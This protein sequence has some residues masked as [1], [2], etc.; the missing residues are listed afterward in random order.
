[1]TALWEYRDA[2]GDVVF[3]V[4][5]DMLMIDPTRPTAPGGEKRAEEPDDFD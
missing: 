1:M 3:V 2:S 4:T 5:R